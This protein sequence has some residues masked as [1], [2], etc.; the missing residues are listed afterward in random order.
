MKLS[1][2]GRPI[3]HGVDQMLLREAAN[4]FI[5]ILMRHDPS[6]SS[7]ITVRLQI[8][9]N[10]LHDSGNA[11]CCGWIKNRTRPDDFYLDLDSNLSQRT[12]LIALGHELVHVKQMAMGER[13][14]NGNGSILWFGMPYDTTTIDY[15]DLPWEIEAHGREYGLYDRFIHS[16]EEIDPAKI[17]DVERRLQVA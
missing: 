17:I 15:Y 11:G 14:E 6:R 16:S 7:E 8:V 1:I 12:A 2:I 3:G 4:F 9:P 10:L 5:D 13:Y